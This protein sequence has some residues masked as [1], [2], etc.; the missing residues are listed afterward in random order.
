MTPFGARLRAAL[1]DRGPLC[2]GIDPHRELLDAWG[3][4][5]SIDGLT[6]F[7]RIAVAA[8]AAQC[9]AIK[10]QS[11]FFERFGSAGVAV[12]E[13]TIAAARAAGAI[14]ITDVKRGDIGSTAAGYAQSY[15]N[16]D[17]P[18]FSDA[19]TVSPYLGV[20]SL[21]PFVE[22]ASQT[23]T[24]VFVLALTS[25]PGARRWQRAQVPDGGTVSGEVFGAL[26]KWNEKAVP[27]GSFGAVV[28]ATVGDTGHD[29]STVNG[30]FLAP[31]I[32]AQGATAHDLV[33]VFGD[34]RANVVPATSRAV[35]SAG[36]SVAALRAAAR[37]ELA[38]CAAALR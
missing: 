21:L 6:E 3:L 36:P 8:L 24:G 7:C 9:A 20:E 11:A 4:S 28:G 38:A 33:R 17:A 22:L 12:L 15:L 29:L 13:E 1:D 23:G 10:P 18:L 34:A 30:P 14:V 37:A 19:I 25:N 32:G 27:L 16:P 31:G 5:D 35:L 26:A 2:V